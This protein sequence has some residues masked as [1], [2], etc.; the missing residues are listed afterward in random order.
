[1]KKRDLEPIYFKF[2]NMLEPLDS[3]YL[4]SG[5]LPRMAVLASMCMDAH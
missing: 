4:A 2:G 1:M 5:I 3:Y